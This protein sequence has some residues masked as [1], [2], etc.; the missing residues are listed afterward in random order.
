MQM[1][2]DP[3]RA[4][5]VDARVVGGVAQSGRQTV[6]AVLHVAVGHERADDAESAKNQNSI[7]VNCFNIFNEF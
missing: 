7:Q 3:A 6:D 4:V 1:S 2:A 5:E